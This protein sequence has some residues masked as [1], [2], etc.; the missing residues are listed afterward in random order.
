MFT[1]RTENLAKRF[2]PRKVFSGINFEI[3]TGQSLAVVG[4]NGSGKSTLLK[5]LL[6]QLRPTKG[7]VEFARDNGPMDD[8]AIRDQVSFVAPY[9]TLYDHLT[10]EENLKFFAT[11]AGDSI[12]GKQV[13][14]LLARVGLEGRGLD[15]VVGYSSGMKQRLKYAVAMLKKPAFLILDEPTSNLDQEGKEIVF[16]LIDEYRKES[17]IIIAT[18]ETEE[19]QLAEQICRLGQ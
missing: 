6:A 7:K 17:I 10:A 9:L 14:S 1:L 18:N 4:H 12:T 11:V 19:Y 5:V 16:N 15:D 2:G 13:D 8:A 3:T